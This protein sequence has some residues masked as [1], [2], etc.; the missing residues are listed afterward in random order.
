MKN[1]FSCLRYQYGL[2]GL[3][4]WC[5]LLASGCAASA[6]LPGYAPTPTIS[7]DL[8]W[9]RQQGFALT[10]NSSVMIVFVYPHEGKF[11]EVINYRTPVGEGLQI[12]EGQNPVTDADLAFDILLAYAWTPPYHGLAA[13]EIDSLKDL[14]RQ[15]QNANQEYRAF[16]DFAEALR[17][18]IEKVDELQEKRITNIPQISIGNFPVIDIA[19]WWDLICTIPLNIFDLCLLEPLLREIHEQGVEID[20]LMRT[21]SDD[22]LALINLLEAQAGGQTVSGLELK[23]KAEKALS[24]LNNLLSKLDRFRTSLLELRIVNQEVID[25]L[26]NRR[27]SQSV[28][29]VLTTVQAVTPSLDLNQVIDDL[30]NKF[31]NLDQKLETYLIKAEDMDSEIYSR[32]SLLS[33]AR[34]STDDALRQSGVEWRYRP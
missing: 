2:I 16:F 24:S 4:L 7:P 10:D 25:V 27:W 9:L 12:R 1:K 3:F 14:Q 31:Q 5:S 32:I 17:P 30:V 8:V 26:G 33:A 29:V 18:L 34:A 22:L 19:N 13:A 23:L 15:L 28:N 20:N 11:Y 6:S 21:S